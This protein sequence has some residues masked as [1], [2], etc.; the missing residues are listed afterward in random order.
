[1]S[2]FAF[3]IDNS[4][5]SE[6]F[7][8]GEDPPS[9][10]S[11]PVTPFTNNT[12]QNSGYS[13]QNKNNNNSHLQT[14]NRNDVITSNSFPTRGRARRG[15]GRGRGR[16]QGGRP[17]HDLATLE[18]F[19]DAV[20]RGD[21]GDVKQLL[22]GGIDPNAQLKSNWTAL[23]FGAESGR[24]A[25][26]ELLLRYSANPNSQCDM[27]TALMVCCASRQ[28]EE[29]A[30]ATAKLLLEAH[31]NVNAQ[32]RCK[33]TPFLYATK[34]CHLL[35]L[36]LLTRSG[37]N[38]NKQEMR[39]WSALCFAAHT[40][41][42][43]LTEVLL[44]CGIDVSLETREGELAADIAD[45]AGHYEVSRIIRTHLDK[46]QAPD[47]PEIELEVCN[48]PQ[49][50]DQ[51]TTHIKSQDVTLSTRVVNNYVRYGDIELFL[52]GLELPDLIDIFQSQGIEFSELISMREEDLDRI[53]IKDLS[54]RKKILLAITEVHARE[55]HCSPIPTQNNRTI[56]SLELAGVLQNF[57]KHCAYIK[58]QLRYIHKQL[59]DSP[60]TLEPNL[61]CDE[62]RL[63][64]EGVGTAVESANQLTHTLTA[65]ESHISEH[66]GLV[67][68]KQTQ[69]S[70]TFLG[71]FLRVGLVTMSASLLG[72]CV[73]YF[74]GRGI[75]KF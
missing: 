13:Y 26:V 68:K 48:T 53:G 39:G 57:S 75:P 67:V 19:R 60:G 6:E 42:I 58:A 1:M 49:T 36:P 63:V 70:G 54:N 22:D 45:N 56:T 20:C 55:W 2:S 28:P 8:L 35:L 17:S 65:I 38:I 29:T 43:S 59:E 69:S 30:H 5:D 21:L 72:G 51:I 52:I 23:M 47:G 12:S 40:G 34:H 73:V 62:T 15:R 61:E 9:I 27:F 25:V 74:V 14:T 41:N 31:A 71:T 4:S 3:D 18:A 16:G 50:A 44:E 11:K 64:C 46:N 33:M 32:D 37:A 24:P 10:E 7:D 66:T